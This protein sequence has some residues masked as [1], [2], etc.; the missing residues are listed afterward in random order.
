MWRS[1]WVLEFTTRSK[2]GTLK[3]TVH[4]NVH[5]FEDGNVQLDDR[6]APRRHNTRRLH[7]QRAWAW[8][9]DVQLDGHS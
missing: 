1:H 2:S 8:H 4:S 5:Y 3:G 9:S 7:I 6:S